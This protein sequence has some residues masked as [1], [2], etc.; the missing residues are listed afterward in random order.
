MTEIRKGYGKRSESIRYV[1]DLFGV[2]GKN[3]DA[4]APRTRCVLTEHFPY[5]PNA[6]RMLSEHFPNTHIRYIWKIYE[7]YFE[8]AHIFFEPPNAE[9]KSQYAPRTHRKLPEYDPLSFRTPTF[10]F[11]KQSVRVYVHI[12]VFWATE[13]RAEHPFAARTHQM[14]LVYDSLAFRTPEFLFGKRTERHSG[15]CDRAIT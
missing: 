10:L 9:P 1:L 15:N 13:C 11:G 7:N 5:M 12:R 4:N 3:T 6:H 8:H 2:F 14:L